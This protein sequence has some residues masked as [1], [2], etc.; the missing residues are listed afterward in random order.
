MANDMDNTRDK[1]LDTVIRLY[2]QHSYEAIST[3][4]IIE[5]VGISKGTLYW[6]FAKKEDM[7]VE[8]YK[9]CYRKVVRH[10][11]M[12]SDDNASA[13]DCLKRRLKN[14]IALNKTD[15]DYVQTVFKH[16][17]VITTHEEPILTVDELDE[18]NGDIS[19]FVREGIKNKE[20]V[21]LPECFLVTMI[22]YTNLAFLI[23]LNKHPFNYENDAVIDKMIDNLY[24]FLQ[25]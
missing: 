14:I 1:I 25:P 23:Y 4:Q 13:I 22:L 12:G 17:P 15:P 3:K 21:N 10:S 11:R 20:I 6:H 16:T 7:F 9:Y 8:A 2:S 5:E 18:L 24:R 19:K